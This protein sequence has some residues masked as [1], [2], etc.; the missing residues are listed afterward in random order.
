MP[1]SFPVNIEPMRVSYGTDIQV[2]YPH[3]FGMRDRGMERFIN[4][5][6]VDETQQL[7]NIQ[8]AEMP[9][10]LVEMDG[11]FETKNNQRDV[12][13]LSFYNYAYHYQAAHGMT[14]IKSLTFDLEN[15]SRCSLSDLFKQGSNY[16]DRLSELINAQ[17]QERD[18]GTFEDTVKIQ[19]DQDFYI[20]DKA[21]VI[22][23][24][25]YEITPY[26]FGF[27]MFPISVYAIRDIINENG[28]LGRMAENN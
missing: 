14:Y 23:F 5:N 6:I 9:T 2:I 17:I 8:V 13:S 27:P 18:I 20:A 24:Q 19:P 4:Q 21:L 15:K 22:Y 7:I 11:S 16:V 25:L 28:P 1:Q 26:V 12:L 3:V 10:T